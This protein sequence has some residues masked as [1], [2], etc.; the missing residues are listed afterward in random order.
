MIEMVIVNLLDNAMKYS[1][2]DVT[3][4]LGKKR[5]SVKDKGIGISEDDLANIQTKFYRV[6]KNSWDNSMGLGLAIVNYILNLH[7]KRLD[8]KSEPHVGSSFGF[9]I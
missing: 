9:T 8:I 4:K 1:S 5:L 3:I 6:D 2:D 7:D